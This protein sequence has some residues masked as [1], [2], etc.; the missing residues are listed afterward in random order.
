ML[1]T[2][3]SIKCFLII[4]SASGEFN[5]YSPVVKRSLLVK[6]F[7][8]LSSILFFLI[9]HICKTSGLLS[10]MIFNHSHFFN[11]SKLTKHFSECIFSG[12]FRKTCNINI[13][14]TFVPLA[15]FLFLFCR[16]FI[17]IS[18]RSLF[19]L[20]NTLTITSVIRRSR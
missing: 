16:Q 14:F 12:A 2:E 4:V 19:F 15:N 5:F 18:F 8:C 7:D 10:F 17:V 11:R 9:Q 13:T 6:L 1:R 20:T 3:W